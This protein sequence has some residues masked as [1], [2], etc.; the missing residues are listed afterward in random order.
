MTLPHYKT[1]CLC[2]DRTDIRCDDEHCDIAGPGEPGNPN[3]CRICWNRLGRNPVPPPSPIKRLFNFA[4]AS[5]HHARRGLPLASEGESRRR[6]GICERCDWYD[7]AA[8][9]CAKCG[10]NMHAKTTWADAECPI[11]KWTKEV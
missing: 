8:D 2:R 5:F 6:L 4:V 10:C 3:S 9:R 1:Y 11:G 7:A